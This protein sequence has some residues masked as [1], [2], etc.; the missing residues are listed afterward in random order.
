MEVFKKGDVVE[1]YRIL[2][3][4]G[5]GAASIIYIAQ[6][7][8]TK[9]IWALKDVQRIDEKSERFLEQAEAEYKIAQ[10]LQH[11]TIRKIPKM[12]KK[13]KPKKDK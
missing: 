2:S 11:E 3:E 8:K 9:Q 6:D 5:R 4:L 13:K 7:E 10:K 1:G 12:V